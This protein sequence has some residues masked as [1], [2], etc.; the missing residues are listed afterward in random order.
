MFKVRHKETRVIRTVYG[1]NGTHFLF[2]MGEG[3]YYLPM[4][5][6]EPVEEF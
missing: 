4:E 5:H 1:W 3:W 6:Y 2:Y